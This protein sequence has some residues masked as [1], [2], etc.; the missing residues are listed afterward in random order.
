MIKNSVHR[1]CVAFTGGIIRSPQSRR[2]GGF[3]NRRLQPAESEYVQVPPHTASPCGTC[4]M[5]GVEVAQVVRRLKPAV[6]KIPSLRDF[7]LRRQLLSGKIA[8][9]KKI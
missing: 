9:Q 8:P 6:N 5:R 7:C 2:D 4:G 3:I 1:F